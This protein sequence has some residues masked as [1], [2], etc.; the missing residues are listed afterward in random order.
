MH[1]Y[2][3]SVSPV[4]TSAAGLASAVAWAGGGYVLSANSI[5]D[6][7]A[8]IIGITGIA[9]TD[10][11]LKTFTVTGTGPNGEAISE[12]IAGPNG[13]VLVTTTRYFTTITSVTVSATT[14]ADT[15]NIGWTAAATSAIFPLNWRQR[16]M[17]VSLGLLITGT[18]SVTVQHTFDKLD[19]EYATIPGS[20]TWWPHSSLVTKTTSADGNYAFPVT[21]TRIL[22]N[23]VTNGATVK[24][25]VAQGA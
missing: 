23:S 24:F 21:A 8:H 11:S 7:M 13:A 1:P 22:I 14:G 9:A 16:S 25:F 18:I 17:E 2:K 15:F 20:I 5:S 12:G 19:G 10:H 3:L 6:G 4:T